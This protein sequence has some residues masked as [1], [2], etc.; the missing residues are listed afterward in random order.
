MDLQT[1]TAAAGD[2]NR[3]G[4]ADLIVGDWQGD[5]GGDAAGEA[6]VVF[7]APFGAG[8]APVNT[9]GTGAAEMFIGGVGNDHL[10]GGGG[11]DVF[12]GGAGN[13]TITASDFA[14]RLVDGGS[15]VDTLVLQGADA[16]FDFT[17]LADTK[18]QSIEAIDFTGTG[19]NTLKFGLTDTLNLSEVPNF[20]FTGLGP[21]PKAVVIDG[22]IGDTLQ[23]ALDARGT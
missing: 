11:A 22:D 7:G 23:L 15:G 10:T 13:D 20:D 5:D 6:Y 14:F 4:F 18:V 8:S 21:A 9:T 16:T 19:N 3:D 2:I 17:A 12:H 1:R